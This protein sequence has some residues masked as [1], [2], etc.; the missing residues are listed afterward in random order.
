[1]K[2][3]IFLSL[4]LL[5]VF[6]A[7]SEKIYKIYKET[8]SFDTGDWVSS[9][10]AIGSDGTIY[11]GS[12]DNLYAINPDGTKKW[13]FET[14]VSSS[15]AIG[16]D[17]TI[18]VGSDDNLYAINPDGTKKWTFETSVSS[19][20]AIGSDGTIYVRSWD[21]KL[22]A[23]NPDGTLKWS[24]DTG[25]WVSSSPLAIGSDGTIYVGSNDNL[26]AI[27]PDGTKKWSF[28][29]GDY[30]SSSPAI[31][32]DGTIYVG[33]D[34]NLYAINPDGTLKWSF[35]T[36]NYVSSSPAIGS[37][38]TIY[39]GSWDQKLYA[40]NPDGTLK[41]SF[42]TGD[43]VS[44]SPAIGS[45]GTIYVG[46]H[47]NNLYAINQDG[48]LK[49]Y[50][51]G[52]PSTVPIIG[53]DDTI[54]VGSLDHHL[55]AINSENAKEIENRVY[56]F[57]NVNWG[58]SKE[59]VKEIETS[60]FIINL[61]DGTL[62]YKGTVAGEKVFIYYEFYNNALIQGKYAFLI[63]HS[64]E[65][66]YIDDYNRL[67]GLLNKKYGKAH[68]DEQIWKDNLYKD[69]YENWGFAISTGDMYYYSKWL[70]EDIKTDIEMQLWGENYEVR[71]LIIY[72]SI[73]DIDLLEQ[74]KEE[75]NLEG[76]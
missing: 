35:E 14:S 73:K 75:E 6:S 12:N 26:Y 2:K 61:D 38:G 49:W 72:K 40:I 1:M 70:T 46:S 34:D 69:D 33:S 4:I 28:D 71:L 32:S 47:D 22:Y 23:I 45:D 36:G 8:W 20:P 19:S 13:T 58:M 53:N 54:Y 18:Y 21:Q 56:D 29:T 64:N 9:S 30:V 37:D 66:D 16:S 39:V 41:W 7:Y 10:P 74:K 5:L 55:Y 31:G 48:S 43:Y 67:K 52:S 25:D 68:E 44:S 59:E 3:F 62:V 57:R 63:D 76:L 17:G 24:F 11:V 42:E 60:D 27:N 50:F 51:K 65:N 15:P